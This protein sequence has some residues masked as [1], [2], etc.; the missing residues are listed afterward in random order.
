MREVCWCGRVLDENKFSSFFI[1]GE[2]L[3]IS[4]NS[5]EYGIVTPERMLSM[6]SSVSTSLPSFMA[7]TRR[8]AWALMK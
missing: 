4:E 1:K 2:L 5:G 6:P 7:L 3:S 8:T